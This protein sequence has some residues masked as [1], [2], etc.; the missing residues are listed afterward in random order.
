MS[1]RTLYTSGY[2]GLDQESFIHKLKSNPIQY[3]IDIR[4][5]PISRKK[6]FSKTGLKEAL[7]SV[8]IDY[9]HYKELGSPS[10]LRKKVRED[11]DF[12]YF[13]KQYSKHLS[14]QSQILKE[15]NKI[16]NKANC[17]L[18]CFEK[19]HEKCHRKVVAE[20]I[21]QMNDD[22]IHVLHL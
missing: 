6:G 2:E 20:K 19:D 7:L 10:E 18:L 21:K 9:L 4:E 14:S 11:G 22:K 5:R 17:C 15:V 12:S 8:D 1:L 13:F 3:V 16:I